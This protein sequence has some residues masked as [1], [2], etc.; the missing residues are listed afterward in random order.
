MD[1]QQTTQSTSTI[2]FLTIT[3]E[4]SCIINNGVYDLWDSMVF[5]DH[6]YNQNKYYDDVPKIFTT[7]SAVV[8]SFV[9]VIKLR[10]RMDP[11]ILS[12]LAY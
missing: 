9:S 7:V 5:V 6:T 12:K 10:L 11:E 2:L 3:L 1:E 8:I 4:V